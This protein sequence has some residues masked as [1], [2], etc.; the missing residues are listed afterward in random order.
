M[1]KF[2]YQRSLFANLTT[3]LILAF[4][5]F[6]LFKLPKEDFPNIDFDVVSVTS[7]FPGATPEQ[8]E[9]LVTNP[10]EEEIRTVFGIKDL[11][12]TSAQGVSSIIVVLDPDYKDK[13]GAITDIQRAV[14]RV[15]DLP[16][17][18]DQPLVQEYK[19]ERAPSLLIAISDVGEPTLQYEPSLELREAAIRLR[20]EIEQNSKVAEVRIDGKDDL[21]YLIEVPSKKLA[22]LGISVDEVTGALLSQNLSVAGGEWQ[23][24]A[25]AYQ[26][27]LDNELTD[28]QKIKDVVLRATVDGQ[29]FK[30]G[31]LAKISLRQKES[32]SYN[33]SGG[34]PAMILNVVR[35]QGADVL[36]V[37][38]EV[39]E[40]TEKF[41]IR[42]A[43]AGHKWE[44][45]YGSD[46]AD[47]VRVRLGSLS[48]SILIGGIF[49]FL[50]L[51]LSLDYRTAIM[52]AIG[53]PFSFLGA[54][55]LMPTLGLTLNLLTMFGFVVVL[56]MLVDDA[57][58]VSE[59]IFSEIE[60]GADRLTAAIE[61]TKKVAIPV[62]G[63]VTTTL[64][65]F[66]PLVF[67]SGIFGKF[68]KFIP[69]VVILCL[70]VSL[71][72][73]FFLL[74][75][76]M[77]DFARPHDPKWAN[78][79]HP[80][81]RVRDFYRNIASWCI[82]HR[83]A[84]TG[85]SWLFMIAAGASFILFGKYENFPDEGIESFYVTLQGDPKL[86]K[87]DM[88]QR[89]LPLENQ[90]KQ[91]P[92]KYV[93]AAFSYVGRIQPGGQETLQEGSNFAQ[94][95]VL[96]SP[97][98]DKETSIDAI[99]DSL[100]PTI[101][102]I[103]NIEEHQL[104]KLAGGPPKGMPITVFFRGD[105][106][107]MVRK[108]V[109]EAKEEL[110]KIDGVHSI[111]D[112]DSP[113]KIENTYELDFARSIQSGV[114]AR[115]VGLG[116][117]MAVDGAYLG[118]VKSDIEST[119]L[120][121]K[122]GK[123]EKPE[124][125]LKNLT[126][127]TNTGERIPISS[128]AKLQTSEAGVYAIRHYG[129]QR[130]IVVSADVDSN[131]ITEGKANKILAANYSKWIEKYP[132]LNIVPLGSNRDTAESLDSL[133]RTA[134]L[135]LMGVAFVM[136]LTMGSLWQPFVVFSSVPL[137]LAG[138]VFI[139]LIHGKPLSFLA[140]FGIV[141]LVGVAVNVGIVLIDRINNLSKTMSY[142]EALLEG[143]VERLRAV[144]LTSS[145]T[146][147]GLMPT[148]YGWGGG[149]PFLKPMALAL[150]WGIAFSTILGLTTIPAYLAV[151]VD[152]FDFMYKRFNLRLGFYRFVHQHI[153]KIKDSA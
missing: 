12:S 61:G 96:L 122:V 83:Y 23:G 52:V 131:V 113:G 117:Q 81:E 22:E 103:P 79:R 100:K 16:E 98:A 47:V 93:D 28:I 144:L 148:A 136:V 78:K 140:L 71:V 34:R 25:A 73:A 59:A 21:E 142:R 14:D 36:Q 15:S 121:I 55:I 20:R 152:F 116:L 85:L 64:L 134:I 101:E 127:V 151:A 17:D 62:F 24:D 120:R 124:E 31:D 94:L 125:A 132:G 69:L 106:L 91:L 110:G 126:A 60:K 80:F 45:S 130:A 92:R 1:L 107:D 50:I 145:T 44:I 95:T 118:D 143:S 88:V 8:V 11:F 57:I 68:V 26:Y 150:G 37:T 146:V 128:L 90:I 141:G 13:E 51:L 104:K 54:I 76:H 86:S 97:E 147:F 82:R 105:D 41:K 137:G 138:I 19:T 4:G 30:L 87:E 33:R 119:R 139:F 7:I 84:V 40:M 63:S 77:R 112:S 2:L 75:T 10:L 114:N 35:K 46:L 43:S 70:I 32:L 58:V 129:G 109:E 29:V 135:A 111:V 18:V 3:I 6:S 65:A 66:A 72:E 39:R 9:R 49:V 74:P 133:M 42:E 67:M 38:D 108:V 5:I 89:I 56:G 153:E 48:S 115:S 53:I 149:D 102:A 99:M 27:R 123:E